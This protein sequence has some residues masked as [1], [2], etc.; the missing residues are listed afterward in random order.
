MPTIPLL[1]MTALLVGGS[2]EHISY[3]DVKT[4]AQRA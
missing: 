3:T 1:L 4:E 2:Y